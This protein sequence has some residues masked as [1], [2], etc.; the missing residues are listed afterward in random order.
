[1]STTTNEYEAQAQEAF[2]PSRNPFFLKTM[3]GDII[4]CEAP[5]PL[6]EPLSF[7]MLLNCIINEIDTPNFKIS[8]MDQDG[9]YTE[10]ES[11][12]LRTVQEGGTLSLLVADQGEYVV[13]YF[14][15]ASGTR[16]L[17][18]ISV[19]MPCVYVRFRAYYSKT[20]EQSHWRLKNGDV[21]VDEEFVDIHFAVILPSERPTVEDYQAGRMTF[22]PVE[23]IPY[24]ARMAGEKPYR[25]RADQP[26]HDLSHFFEELLG[27][28]PLKEVP[29]TMLIA[30]LHSW[31]ELVIGDYFLDKAYTMLERGD[32]M[33]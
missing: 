25:V 33:V 24:S 9:E 21:Y 31:E 15:V 8:A 28:D 2:M 10:D 13:D 7:M 18:G 6:D 14:L 4:P 16:F 32:R 1:M 22:Y 30:I 26:V 12:I 27:Q 19:D 17:D 11:T 29:P 23:D 20:G 5:I 3:A